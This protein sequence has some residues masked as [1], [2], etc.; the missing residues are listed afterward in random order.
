MATTT[1]PLAKTMKAAQVTKPGAGFQ[2]VEREFPSPVPACADQSAG[3]W[4]L[5]QRRSHG[6]R[7]WPGI[8]SPRAGHEVAGVIDESGRRSR[9]EGGPA[10]GCRLAWR[11]RQHCRECRRGDF[12]NCQTGKIRAEL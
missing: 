12:R 5:P 11:P 7:L 3:L 1:V 8:V 10:C 9:L 4:H 6:G 2:I